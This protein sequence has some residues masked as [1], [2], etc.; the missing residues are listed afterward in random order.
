MVS[1]VDDR[2]R[3][4]LRSENRLPSKPGKRPLRIPNQAFTAP[5]P[6]PPPRRHASA[7]EALDGPRRARS[8]HRRSRGDRPGRCLGS[9]AGRHVAGMVEPTGFVPGAARHAMPGANLHR[10][11]TREIGRAGRFPDAREPESQDTCPACR[12]RPADPLPHARRADQRMHR[13]AMSPINWILSGR[14]L[15]TSMLPPNF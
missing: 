5:P 2:Q 14:S 15:G 13:M 11:P 4:L 1:I 7:A 3:G 12:R 8:S 9:Q 6:R 10:T